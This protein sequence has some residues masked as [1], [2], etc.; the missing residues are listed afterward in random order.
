[1]FSELQSIVD[2][3]C[4]SSDWNLFIVI[5]SFQSI[6][7][8]YFVQY[9]TELRFKILHSLSLRDNPVINTHTL[10]SLSLPDNPVLNAHTKLVVDCNKFYFETYLCFTQNA[11]SNRTYVIVITSC[12]SDEIG[13][14]NLVHYFRNEF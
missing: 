2:C 11:V 6:H 1:M 4:V 7:S 9:S 12:S 10:H 3:F 8:F 14:L 13:S 5:D